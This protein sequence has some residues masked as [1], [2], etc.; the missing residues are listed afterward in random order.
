MFRL[1]LPT[2]VVIFC[3]IGGIW[4]AYFYLRSLFKQDKEIAGIVKKTCIA[5]TTIILISF[6]IYVINIASVN[7]IPREEI[8]RSA[9]E[10]GK[11]NF[12]QQILQQANK[13][14]INDSTKT[15]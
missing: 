11:D 5:I 6:V 10:Q 14:K 2:L 7:E 1:L 4:G 12:E 15:K 13:P 8:D 3:S 9:L